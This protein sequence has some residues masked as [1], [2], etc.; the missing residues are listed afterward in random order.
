MNIFVFVT[1]GLGAYLLGS[2]LCSILLSH[3]FGC[4]DP[5]ESGSKNPGATNML[6]VSTK[7]MALLTFL[8]DA[9]K[10]ALVV[11]VARLLGAD[12]LEMI[13]IGFMVFLGHVF[14]LY[15]MFRGGKG[16]ATG[17]GVVLSFSPLL[18]GTLCIICF[19]TYLLNYQETLYQWSWST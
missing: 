12:A 18:G 9:V 14:P 8:G 2:I 16:V 5:R 15:F 6:R 1:L 19:I 11:I 7:K 17:L 4:D 13:I 10:G 3:V